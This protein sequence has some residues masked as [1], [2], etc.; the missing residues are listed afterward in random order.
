MLF[1]N[2]YALVRAQGFHPHV[3]LYHALRPGHPALISDLMEEFRAPIVDATVL[4]LLH[5]KQVTLQDFRMPSPDD[6]LC[7]MTDAA[8]K[9]VTQTFE[10]VFNR[11]VTHPDASERCDYRR[12]IALQAQRLVAVIQDGES[13]YQPFVRR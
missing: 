11:A 10:T 5:R 6:A 2:T 9:T 13:M 3:G 12:A 4:A 1:Y 7:R 8:R